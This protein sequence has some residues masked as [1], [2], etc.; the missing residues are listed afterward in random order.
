MTKQNDEELA[1]RQ[2]L[3]DDYNHY[4]SRC[5]KIRTKSGAIEPFVLNRAQKFI[6]A[7]V[8]HQRQT[9]GKVR[10]IILKS[11]QQGSST[12]I[13][14]R[15]YWRVTHNKGVRAFILTHE[16]DATTNLFEMA[17]R[18]HENCPSQVKPKTKASNAK[19][20]LFASL[21][22]GYKLGTAGNKSVGRSST[23]QFLH[24]CLSEGT[25]IFDPTTGG[26]K[27]IESFSIGDNVLTH[28]GKIAS[29]SYIS[30]QEK[31]CI[32]VTFRTL[33]KFPLIATSEHR[34][35]TKKGWKELGD[36]NIGDSIGYPIRKITNKIKKLKLPPGHFNHLGGGRQNEYPDTINVNYDFGKIVGLY[37]AEG[38]IKLQN[39]SP[40]YPSHIEFAV[41]R[42]EVSRTL[43]WLMPFYD[44]FSSLK[45]HDVKNSLT[46]KIIIYGNRFS[47]LMNDLC[48]RITNK[49]IPYNWITMSKSFCK[50]LI[51]GYLSGDGG[52]YLSSRRIN[53]TSICSAITISLRDLCVSLGYGWASIEHKTAA[54]RSGRNEKEAF[55]F[56]LCGRG[57][58]KLAKEINKP[59]PNVIRPSHTSIKEYA[60]TSIEISNGYAWLRIRKIEKAGI[61]KVY[62]FEID[63]KDHSYCTIHGATHNSESA[64]YKHAD[65]HAK[66]IMQTVP[67]D[68]G[69][70]VFLES[71]ANGVGNWFHQQWQLA[72]SG[73]SDFI[74][75]FVPWFWQ[76][77]YHKPIADKT[78]FL[79]DEDEIKLKEM[80]NLTG[81][82]INWRRMKI[83]DLSVNGVDGVK[84]FNQEYPCTAQEAFVLTGEDNYIS[85]D[86]VLKARKTTNVERYGSK[87]L[88]VDPARFGD[89][90]TAI[91]RRQGRVAYKLETHI[92]KDTMEVVGIVHNIILE[93]QP[94]A[95]CVDVG[96]LGAGIV[97]RLNELGHMDIVHAVN[98]GSKPL[99]ARKYLNKRGELWSTGKQ[100]LIDEPC[101][102]PDNDELHADLCNTKYKIDSNSRLM[103]EKK[104]D[105]K[106]R[107]VRSS[108]CADAFLLT[109]AVPQSA[110]TQNQKQNKSDIAKEI[111]SVHKKISNIRKRR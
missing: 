108:D 55:T 15:F 26:I 29:I 86:L 48:G 13:E 35:W 110:L 51:H 69:T 105:M 77:E 88:G 16:E 104:E 59:S 14:G 9:T 28:G 71:T 39:K 1:V 72:E 103:I 97:D 46:T 24:A 12:Y 21:D 31:K 87:I 85:P 60:A 52:S 70:E 66:G 107:G 106:K 22:S 63:H 54:I 98:A 109:F 92:K 56:T 95:V 58:T 79:L 30:S 111:M 83:I 73:Q 89:D 3:K 32:S 45:V 40:H 2:K 37:L 76:D 57:V 53:A 75:I 100:W 49:H 5:L 11:R 47:A 90:R 68:V 17:N 74:A 67:N 18:F 93:E 10:A 44:Y 84:S 78:K 6:H 25:L 102:L 7:K 8:E 34:F 62:D 33:G 19:E 38:H 42:K 96:G 94:D 50:G 27:K 41:H 36:L 91:I 23:I 43:E 4:A 80:F 101:E 64:F 82:Q 99:D 81:E 65:E 20:L 61:K